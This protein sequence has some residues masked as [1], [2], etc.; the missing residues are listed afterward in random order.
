MLPTPAAEKQYDVLLLGA[1]GFTG[2]LA[3]RYLATHQQRAQ[4]TVAFAGRSQAKLEALARDLQLPST[5][6]LVQVDVTD[7]AQVESV[8]KVARV[9]INT[10]GPFRKW[11]TPVVRCVSAFFFSLS[12]HPPPGFRPCG[13]GGE[14]GGG[15]DLD[16]TWILT[17][18]AFTLHRA[19]VRHGVHYV[20][21]T[22]EANWV[23]SIIAE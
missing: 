10:V 5:A 21:I 6:R 8:V 11:G 2:R 19:C 16:C 12:P 7:S 13:Y 23:L 18:R 3:T 20:D 15:G 9:V 1:T 22:G 4:F 14:K 17:K